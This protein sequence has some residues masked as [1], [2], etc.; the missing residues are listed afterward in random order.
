M[1]YENRIKVAIFAIV[2]AQLVLAV[3]VFAQEPEP[4]PVIPPFFSVIFSSGFIQSVTIVIGATKFFRNLL[5]GIKGAPAFII[6]LLVSIGVGEL[7]LVQETG[8][9]YAGGAGIAAG[10]VSAGAFK[11]SKLLGRF[12]AGAFKKFQLG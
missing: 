3:F 7:T 12:F 10:L 8:W 1:G 2:V 6:T 5:G 11:A 4:E 9:L